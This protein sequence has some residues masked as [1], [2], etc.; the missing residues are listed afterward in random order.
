MALRCRA[1]V[2]GGAGFIGSHLC[3]RLV[4]EGYEVICLDNLLTGSE[5]N[6][7]ALAAIPEFHF[8]NVDVTD[9]L[10]I[11]VPVDLV[12]HLA[13]P[14]SPRDYS[15]HP[16]ETLSVCSQ[17][18]HRA[19]RLAQETGARFLLASTSEIYGDPLVHPQPES[20]WGNVNSLGPRAVYDE[21]K[22]YA[23]ALT[24]AYRRSYG[25]DTTIVRI[26]NVYGPQMR[27]G[28][29]RAVP[30]FVEQALSEMSLTITG[31][32]LQTRSLCYIDDLVEGVMRLVRSD[33]PGPVNLGNPHEITIRELAATILELTGSLSKVEYIPSLPDDPRRR[34]PDIT[35]AQQQLGWAPAVPLAEGLRR[36]IV[37]SRRSLSDR[38]AVN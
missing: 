15:A 27:R 1:V 7:E 16:I 20:Y 34:C 38:A 17:G 37:W 36:T 3:G 25:S 8:V 30:T 4:A 29:G 23:E 10:P 24:A 13:C 28:D 31:D 26:F 35:V 18:T 12:L 2:T 14:A 9:K 5:E 6:L 19:L 11:S 22:R 32:G 33:H 21:G